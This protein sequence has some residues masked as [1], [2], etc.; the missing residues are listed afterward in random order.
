MATPFNIDVNGRL[1]SYRYDS[2]AGSAINKSITYN[3]N[4]DSGL[5]G[6]EHEDLKWV[7]WLALAFGILEIVVIYGKYD[8]LNLIVLTCLLAIYLL[9]HFDSTYIKVTITMLI[10]SLILDFIWL[11]MYANQKWNPPSVGNDSTYQQAYMRFIV[12][13]TVCIIVLKVSILVR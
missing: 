6:G 1:S 11:F 12:F 8:F 5:L 2:P 9:N 3:N 10:I 7:L 4:N 13:F